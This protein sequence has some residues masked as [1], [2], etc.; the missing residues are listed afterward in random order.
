VPYEEAFEEYLEM[1]PS[2]VSEDLKENTEVMELLEG[3]GAESFNP[4]DWT[5]IRM[6]PVVFEFDVDKPKEIKPSVEGAT[7]VRGTIREGDTA[8]D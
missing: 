6:D 3:E 8:A 5:G 2:R 4:R 7:W 1:L